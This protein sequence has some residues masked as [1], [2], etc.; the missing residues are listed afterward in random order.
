MASQSTDIRLSDNSRLFS[1]R[2]GAGR[3]FD[4]LFCAL[5]FAICRDAHFEAE[6]L[7]PFVIAACT[8]MLCWS[9]CTCERFLN[10]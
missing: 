3:T 2:V 7:E 6:F 1:V 5:G 9:K 4:G 10:A 8:H